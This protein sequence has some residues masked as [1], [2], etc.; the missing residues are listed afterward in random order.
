MTFP[1]PLSPSLMLLYAIINAFGRKYGQK[2]SLKKGTVKGR[3]VTETGLIFCFLE[4][5]IGQVLWEYGNFLGFNT[6]GKDKGC[7]RMRTYLIIVLVI[8]IG[9]SLFGSAKS[10]PINDRN[11]QSYHVFSKTYG[12]G[13]KCVWESVVQVFEQNNIPIKS[14]DQDSGIIVSLDKSLP[15][16]DQKHSGIFNAEDFD[17]GEPGRF[18]ISQRLPAHSQLPSR[19]EKF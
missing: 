8:L 12:L 16:K 19:K 15:S 14:M 1:I 18:S 17:C 11:N 13:Y 2:E 10:S 5:I 6:R 9:L 4:L 7:H 3:L